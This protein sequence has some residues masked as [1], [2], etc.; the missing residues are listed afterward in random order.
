[1]KPTFLLNQ[2]QI[3]IK[4]IFQIKII[5]QNLIL[6]LKNLDKD[7]VEVVYLNS[8]PTIVPSLYY[9]EKI[10][11]KYLETNTIISKSIVTDTSNDKK[12]KVI[13]TI[14][15]ELTEVIVKNNLKYSNKNY[16]TYLYNFLVKEFQNQMDFPSI[17][18]ITINRLT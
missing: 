13:Y 15:D 14:S 9:E 2:Q 17:F 7:F 16:F 12:I 4:F 11:S 1:M 3:I 6:F 8:Q 10:K 18:T 5:S